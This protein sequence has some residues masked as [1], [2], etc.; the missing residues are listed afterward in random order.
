M[1]KVF[2]YYPAIAVV[3]F[4]L[5][6]AFWGVFG[7]IFKIGNITWRAILSGVVTVVILRIIRLFSWRQT[8]RTSSIDWSTGMVGVAAAV[9]GII[10]LNI[11]EDMMPLPDQMQDTFIAMAFSIEGALCIAVIAPLVEEIVFRECMLG[12]MLRNGVNRWVAIVVSSLVFGIIHLNLAQI[13]FATAIGIILGI[14][15]YKSGNIV[16]T[17]IIHILNNSAAL[18]Q[19]RVLGDDVADFRLTEWLGGIT[20]SVLCAVV[21]MVVCITLLRMF[22]KTYKKQNKYETVY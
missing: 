1:R 14:V 19:M 10:S 7:A 13:P 11:V 17:S 22:W 21:A 9:F 15:Y 4:L 3:T 18:V 6:Q 8:F 5:V 16:L 2:L 12:H 20:T